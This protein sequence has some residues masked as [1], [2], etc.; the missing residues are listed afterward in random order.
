M[1]YVT[2]DWKDDFAVEMALFIIIVQGK[3]DIVEWKLID[4]IDKNG[5]MD[6]TNKFSPDQN[7]NWSYLLDN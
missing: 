4:K 2:L 5:W 6:W 3:E 7:G 1:V